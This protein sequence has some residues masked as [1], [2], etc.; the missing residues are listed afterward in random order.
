MYTFL[1]AYIYLFNCAHAHAEWC[2]AAFGGWQN[3][4]DAQRLW[5]SGRPHCVRDTEL[6]DGE[7]TSHT[8]TW[9][10]RRCSISHLGLGVSVVA[11][12]RPPPENIYI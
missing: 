10:G 7:N 9:L 12:P 4:Q 1:S 5:G 8:P 3:I 2:F 6:P 11:V